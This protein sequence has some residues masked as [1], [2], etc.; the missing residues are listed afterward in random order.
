MENILLPSKMTFTE[1]EKPHEEILTIE[2]LHHGYGTTVGNA[3]RRVMLS[4]LEG[5]AVTAVKIKG[6]QHEFSS[7]DG[8]KEDVLEIIL[9]LKLMR[10]KVHSSEPVVLKLSAKKEGAVTAGDIDANADV[11]IVNPDLHLATMTDKSQELNMEITVGR[12]RGFVPTEERESSGEIG[13]MAVD[14]MYSP[15]V[16]VGLKVENT[17]VGEITN[18]DKVIMNIQTD[19]TIDPKEAVSQATQVVLN[20]FNW[21]DSQLQNASLTE[22]L[23]SAKEEKAQEAEEATEEAAE[24]TE[25]PDSEEASE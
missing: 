12:G 11:E 9:N 17:R 3:L 16:A 22:K 10:M 20:H 5:A 2:P 15:I 7:I 14:A 13:L 1:G 6:V 19:G 21:I 23:E 8:V 25:T 24:A 4:S 18:Y